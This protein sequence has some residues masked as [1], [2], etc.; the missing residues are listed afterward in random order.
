M[1]SLSTHINSLAEAL[2]TNAAILSFANTNYGKLHKIY[3]NLDLRNPP[4]EAD[5]PY[6]AFYPQLQSYGR[7]S[8]EQM[9]EIEVVC[10][11]HDTA[12]ITHFC[13]PPADHTQIPNL[14]E[15]AGVRRLENF[16]RTVEKAIA[17]VAI[18]NA[19]ISAGESDYETI[20]FFPFFMVGQR[21]TIIDHLCIG[22]DPLA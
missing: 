1:L 8:R 10:C 11:L 17:A 13:P 12:L 16:R 15:Y 21:F 7:E 2:A 6:I 4:A 9:I 20:D 22:E 19:A 3:V 14:V 5:C 18:G